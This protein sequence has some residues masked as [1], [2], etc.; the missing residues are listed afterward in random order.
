MR[1]LAV[2]LAPHH[3]PQGALHRAFIPWL[4]C[5]GREWLHSALALQLMPTAVEG[6]TA[7]G[8]PPTHNKAK[9]TAAAIFQLTPDG[10]ILKMWKDWDKLSMWRQLG[11]VSGE[12]AALELS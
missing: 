10:L 3:L 5:T 7:A 8:I 11:W 4:Q 1:E 12:A 2:S 6:P 9:W